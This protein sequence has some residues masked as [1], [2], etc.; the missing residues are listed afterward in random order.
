M[1]RLYGKYEPLSDETQKVLDDLYE[2]YGKNTELKE[3]KIAY[4][5]SYDQEV[6]NQDMLF[7]GANAI[8]EAYMLRNTHKVV[9]DDNKTIIKSLKLR[10]FKDDEIEDEI[11][12][13]LA[14]KLIEV[15][16]VAK[17]IANGDIDKRKNFELHEPT[18]YRIK[19]GKYEGLCFSSGEKTNK[20][21]SVESALF[22]DIANT[23]FER[24]P[25]SWQASNFDPFEF[26]YKL[27]RDYP[28][29]TDEE[30]AAVVHVYWLAGNQW[31]I[32]Y[33]DPMGVPYKELDKVEQVKDGDNVLVANVFKTEENKIGTE[34][35]NK[36][37]CLDIIKVAKQ[38]LS[39]KL[40]KEAEKIEN[41]EF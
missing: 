37:K 39:K 3:R 34:N 19:E 40:K 7:A 4:D 20:D 6:I 1:E 16:V 31:A 21:G 23:P 18:L 9:L 14:D 10:D 15:E 13:L 32:E 8:N 36:E 38:M 41:E 28:A 29:L 33:N 30:Y 12:A 26:A 24:L 17:N 11:K 22:I 35:L 25:Q 2:K 27:V 5:V